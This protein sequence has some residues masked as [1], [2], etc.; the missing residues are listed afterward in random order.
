MAKQ[1]QVSSHPDDEKYSDF[2]IRDGIDGRAGVEVYCANAT[3]ALTE[4]QRATGQTNYHPS[5]F[6]A[7]LFPGTRGYLKCGRC[8]AI[9]RINV[10][11][12]SSF[13]VEVMDGVNYCP[14]EGF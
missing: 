6:L 2:Q 5:R 3:C 8:K 9:N 7:V 1:V 10:H 11:S 13:T 12:I 4:K 14:T